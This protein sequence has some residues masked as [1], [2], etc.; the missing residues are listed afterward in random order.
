MGLSVKWGACNLGAQKSH[1][2]GNYYAW[3][4]TEPKS[5][6]SWATY[7][8]SNGSEN[9]LT[10]YGWN[11]SMGIV[12]NIR[13][14]EAKDDA[15]YVKLGS[16]AHIPTD[17]EWQELI[18]N[19]TQKRTTVEGVDGWLFTSKKNGNS[20][21]FPNGGRKTTSGNDDYYNDQVFC[22][23]STNN[24][25]Y[26]SNG[27]IMNAAGSTASVSSISR[28]CGLNI[29]P[30]FSL[31]SDDN[32]PD[33]TDGNI[34]VVWQKDGSKV[35]FKLEELPKVVVDGDLVHVD[36]KE[37]SATF[38]IQDIAKM[39]YVFDYANGIKIINMST[40]KPFRNTQD[41]IIFQPASNDLNVKIIAVS[42]ML[43]DNFV[44]KSGT[45]TSYSFSGLNAGTY[46]IIVNE[47]SY[48]IVVR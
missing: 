7:K 24:N 29:R 38:D 36:S 40:E 19:T 20:I 39:T 32:T 35:G 21:F 15:C 44:V 2:V 33:A 34:L 43:V 4:E 31:G 16:N 1:E 28:A 26:G 25:C 47:V 23:A 14:L 12:D 18:D 42:G 48:K 41:A 9:S 37:E 46:I 27:Q 6:Y 30:V 22:W 3:G 45:M 13:K 5:V 10:K 11:S 17:V 8:Y